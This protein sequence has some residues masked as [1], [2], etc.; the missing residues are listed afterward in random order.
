[1]QTDLFILTY[2]HKFEYHK[3]KT[4]SNY[5]YQH[6]YNDIHLRWVNHLS[7]YIF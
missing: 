7:K 2:F 6:Y 4:V 5:A 1:M 3:N